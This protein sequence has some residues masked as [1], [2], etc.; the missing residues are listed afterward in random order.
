MLL[1]HTLWAT[2]TVAGLLSSGAAYADPVSKTAPLVSDQLPEF[3]SK[4]LDIGGFRLMP[5]VEY[6]IYADDN[7]YA[8]PTGTQADAAFIITGGLEAKGRVG[9]IDLT[10]T[11][12]TRIRRYDKLTT[13]NSEGGEVLIG[14]GWQPKESQKFGLSGGWRRVV[15]ERGDPEALQLTT[16]GPRL[17]NIFEAEGKFS[18]QGG[19]MLIASDVAWRKY[20]FLGPVN[21]R[22]DF[23]SQFGSVTL[24]R[25]IGSRFYGTATAFITNRDFRLP[26]PA[27]LSQDET[28]VGGRLGIATKERGIIEGRAS[29]GLFKLNP[30]DPLQKSRTG[31]STDIS[32]TYRPQQRTAITLN[33]FSGDVAT[34]RLG[35]VARA[36]TTAQLSVQQE[37]RHNL[38]A[39]AAVSYLRAEFI[40]SG[41]LEKAISPRVEV[42]WLASKRI[43]I[44]GYVSYTDR[45]SN[46]A[47]E[48]FDRA[49]GGVSFRLRF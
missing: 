24:G 31:I 14:L 36:D 30:A 12:K 3:E 21:D 26:T 6:I 20:D 19:V 48:N 43:S 44:A 8:A 35:A 15:E 41:D 32:M 34:F 10:A 46:I 11:A 1:R 23:T 47:V 28:T 27:G 13:E 4:G 25:S 38:Y 33:V 2:C 49:R 45:T 29:I 16:T 39:T 7:V 9:S 17:L 37:I 40:G 42:E 5:D 18:H 22:R